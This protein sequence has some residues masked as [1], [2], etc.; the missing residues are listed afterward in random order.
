MFVPSLS[1]Q[2]DR[3]YVQMAKKRRFLINYLRVDVTPAERDQHEAK[4]GLCQAE[5]D[6]KS[7]DKERV[8][9]LQDLAYVKRSHGEHRADDCN[10]ALPA[11]HTR[12]PFSQ[13]LSYICPESVLVN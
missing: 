5:D 12:R 1:W 11:K 6:K 10:P 2:N 8:G 3:F 13:L 9:V 4:G 7:D